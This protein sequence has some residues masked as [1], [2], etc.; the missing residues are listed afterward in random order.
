VF[1]G[2]SPPFWA[3]ISGDVSAENRNE[4]PNGPVVPGGAL[5]R[6]METYPNL[7]C[8][9]DAVSGYN[10]LTR[11]PEYG[12]EFMERFSDRIL[13]GTDICD[14]SNTHQHAEYL[15]TSH[16]EGRIS[17]AAFENISWRTANQL[18]SLRL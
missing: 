17:D 15:R 16:A 10:G 3:E 18:F 14:P 1:I 4:Y 9:W 8:G 2:H 6:L 5:P 12:W 11:D 13:F 7:Y